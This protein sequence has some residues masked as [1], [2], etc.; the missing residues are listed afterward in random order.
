MKSV[1]IKIKYDNTHRKVSIYLNHSL[2]SMPPQHTLKL[3]A[4]TTAYQHGL[5]MVTHKLQIHKL[6]LGADASIQ[7]TS[8]LH[9]CPHRIFKLGPWVL[10]WGSSKVDAALL[11]HFGFR[12]FA[13]IK[14]L[15]QIDGI[16]ELPV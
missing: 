11:N 4:M 8:C 2:I 3:T 5:I 13:P 10:A 9:K 1:L 7:N 16:D 6:K 15:T 12:T 14:R